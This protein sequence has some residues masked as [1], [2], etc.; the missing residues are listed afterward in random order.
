MSHVNGIKLS[1][2]L[3]KKVLVLIT[4]G[5]TVL[6][7]KVSPQAS[8]TQSFIETTVFFARNLSRYSSS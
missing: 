6:Q 1:P 4:Y 3:V 7:I 8:Q 5:G 2:G